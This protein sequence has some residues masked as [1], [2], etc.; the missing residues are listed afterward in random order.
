M[1][2]VWKDIE[3]FEGLYQVSNLERVKSLSHNVA[4]SD[5]RIRRYKEKMIKTNSSKGIEYYVVYLTKDK[6]DRCFLLHRL[7]AIAFIPNPDNKSG[8]NHK[9]GIKTDNRIENLEWATQKENIQ[10]AFEAGLCLTG[11]DHPLSKNKHTR[12]KLVLDTQTG[13]FYENSIEATKFSQGFN[14]GYL[15]RM[16]NGSSRNKTNLMYV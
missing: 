8:V 9:N 4:Y 10:H 15:R 3:G 7:I 11:K 1:E 12:Y 5:G 14:K 2:E 6:K 13:V 16:L